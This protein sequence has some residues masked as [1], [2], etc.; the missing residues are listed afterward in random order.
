MPDIK[1]ALSTALT[2]WEKDDKQQEK[3]V[4]HIPHFKVTN[5]VTRATFEHVKNNPKQSCKTIC[6]ALEKRGYKSSS[7]GSLLT[8][9]V[10]NGLCVRDANSNYSVIVDEYSP[11]KVRKQ[12]KAKQAKQVIEKAKA[13]RGEGIAALGPWAECAG[14]ATLHYTRIP[15]D[16]PAQIYPGLLQN[17]SVLV[18]NGDQDECIPYLQDQQ[19]TEG[20]NFPVKEG[21]R[22]WFVDNQVAGYVTEYAPPSGVRFTFVTVKQA[23]HEVPMYQPA[24]GLALMQR[25][26]AGEPL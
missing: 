25:F 9:F 3:K 22:P 11:I 21:W 14:G 24:R 2:E 6:A 8:Q 19:W 12:L 15:C 5:N 7:I 4:K 1:T 23:G 13:T 20:M 26:V 10:K 16:E 18:Y 17:I